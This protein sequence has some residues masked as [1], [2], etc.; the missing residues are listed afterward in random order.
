MLII[1]QEHII[2]IQQYT[3]HERLTK[4]TTGKNIKLGNWFLNEE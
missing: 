2:N 4:S 1:F 3:K